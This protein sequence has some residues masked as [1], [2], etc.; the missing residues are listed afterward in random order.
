MFIAF[1]G[2]D[3]SGK[4]T[5]A[6]LLV[7][8]LRE[9]G[10]DVLPTRE[11][12]GTPVGE[13]LRSLVLD[14]GHA[15]IDPVTE[16]LVFAASRSAHVR[17]LLRPA[18]EAGRVVVTDRYV[19]SSVAYQGAGRDL[20]TRR[21]A[22]LN[23]WATDGLHPDLTVLLDVDTATA[24]ARRAAREAS[25]GGAGPDRMEAE[26]EAFHERIRQA[27]LERAAT[28]PGRYLVIDRA[29][30]VPEIAAA[31]LAHVTGLLESRESSGATAAE[32]TAAETAAAEDAAAEDAA[33][34]AEGSRP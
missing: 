9:A 32:D 30:P 20:G 16:A 4:S 25:P 17:Q 22:E 10:Y 28:D 33:H 2:G 18:L 5:Q 13:R 1:E 23:E 31:V 8:A 12:G 14:P 6:R 11:P 7:E 21:V 27:F 29:L 3:G 19:D 34:A 24:A 26:P 15:P